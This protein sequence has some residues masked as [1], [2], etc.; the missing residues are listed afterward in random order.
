MLKNCV[1]ERTPELKQFFKVALNIKSCLPSLSFLLSMINYV[2][3]YRVHVRRTD[4]VGVEA[5][6]HGIDEYMEFVNEYFDRLEAKS[7][8]EQ[9]RIYLATDDANLLREAREKYDNTWD[10]FFLSMHV[11]MIIC[12]KILMHSLS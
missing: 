2:P 7:P 3:C 8:V 11:L 5:A 4:K 9:R 6:F 12:G 1:N 10:F